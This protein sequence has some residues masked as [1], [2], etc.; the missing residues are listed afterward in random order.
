MSADRPFKPVEDRGLSPAAVPGR[1]G[2]TMRPDAVVPDIHTPYDFY[3][4]N[5]LDA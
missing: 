1:N 4:R 3:E 2:I 5:Y